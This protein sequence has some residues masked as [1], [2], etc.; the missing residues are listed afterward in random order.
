MLVFYALLGFNAL[1]CSLLYPCSFEAKHAHKQLK[2][3]PQKLILRTCLKCSATP[4]FSCA[5][6]SEK[7]LCSQTEHGAE[8]FQV[9]RELRRSGGERRDFLSRIGKF[10]CKHR[11]CAA[12]SFAETPYLCIR[13]KTNTQTDTLKQYDYE[14]HADNENDDVGSHDGSRS[15][16]DG[17]GAW[18]CRPW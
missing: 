8:C 15:E 4:A 9:P 14:D 12:V 17:T 13:T 1:R 11:D 16:H 18:R 7:G 10:P 2:P 6:A 3:P 5:L